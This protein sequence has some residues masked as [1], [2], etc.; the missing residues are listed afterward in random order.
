MS[1]N[2]VQLDAVSVVN[3]THPHTRTH[4]Q[5]AAKA[6][7]ITGLGKSQHKT[8]ASIVPHVRS[9]EN[10]NLGTPLRHH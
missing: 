2:Y 3:R 4:V 8:H 10:I 5:F 1:V 7:R 6:A 9:V